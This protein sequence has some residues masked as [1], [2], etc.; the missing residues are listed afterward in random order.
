MGRNLQSCHIRPLYTFQANRGCVSRKKPI[1]LTARFSFLQ[2]VCGHSSTYRITEHVDP[3]NAWCESRRPL[4]GLTHI[5]E[6]TAAVL[7]AKN[8]SVCKW[9]CQKLCCLSTSESK[10]G[11]TGGASST[12][13]DSMS[14]LW[15]YYTWF[16]RWFT[17]ISRKR[18]YFVGSRSAE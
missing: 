4:R 3:W 15:W 17:Q 12:S 1:F 8:A 16:H 18:H 10:K 2:W 13:S 6:I 5:E 14:G 9:I 11:N 7:L